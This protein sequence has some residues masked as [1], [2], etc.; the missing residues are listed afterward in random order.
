MKKG[1]MVGPQKIELQEFSIPEIAED[2]VLIKVQAC[3]ICTWEQ[4]FYKGVDGAYPFVGGHEIAGVVEKVGSKVAQKLSPKDQVVVASLTRCGECYFCRRGLDNLCENVGN[5]SKPGHLWGPGGFSE[6][7]I[8]KGYEAYKIDDNV[9]IAVATLAEPLACVIKSV[10]RGRLRFGDTAVVLGAG[11]MG[12]LHIQLAKLLGA[13]VIVSE[14]DADRRAKALEFGADVVCDPFSEDL[15]EIVKSHTDQRGAEAV[16]F[17]AG[18][19]KAVEQG[20]KALAKNGTLVVYG[21]IKPAATIPLDPNDLHYDE[22]YLTGVTKHSKES[23]R[24]A[25][26]ILSKGLLSLDE[27]I[28]EKVPFE[29]IEEGFDRASSFDTYRVVLTI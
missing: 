1:V 5:E 25:A 9:D 15:L 21:A 19:I 17:T 29:K 12:V 27:L 13:H 28:T 20:I 6:Y 18:G 10:E 2:E 4:R 16:F 11:V 22:V 7:F 26:E 24:E 23:F 14:P 3:G 8:A